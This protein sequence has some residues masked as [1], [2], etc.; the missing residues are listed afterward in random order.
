[1]GRI[2]GDKRYH[3]LN[4]ELRK[5]FGQKV[6]KLSLDGGF[7]CPNRDGTI[8]N[9]GCIFCSEEGSGEFTASRK[10]SIQNQIDEQINFLSPKWKT[11]KYIAYFQNFT[12]TYSTIE[13]LRKKYYDAISREDIVGLAIAT[14][15]DCLP[16]D[17]LDLLY[18]INNKTYLWVELGLQTIHEK[19][20]NVIR[21]G[22]DL[23]C[24]EK[25]ISDLKDR[26]IRVV[27]HLI[28][29]LPGEEK[30]DIL[31]SVKYVGHTN[32]WGIKLHL[33]Y[34]L[35]N[36]D[37]YELYQKR[38]FHVLSQDEYI[39]LVVDSLEV[40]PPHMVI[41]RLTGDGAKKSLIAPRWSLNKLAVLSGIDKELKYRDSYQGKNYNGVY[42][43]EGKDNRIIKK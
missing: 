8:G 40:L 29:G 11:N 5:E 30:K 22:Y 21:R 31:E 19:T 18:E 28:L 14:R 37:L 6:I 38:P 32:T 24:Y 13:D 39:S 15:P 17:V 33:M 23:K 35:E 10:L 3:T 7:T 4:Y 25:A 20:A 42:F 34:I 16:E 9:K 12:N 1:M 43:Y 26:G 27:T 41:H 2:W 36:T